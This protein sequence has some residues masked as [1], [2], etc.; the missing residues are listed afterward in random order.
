MENKPEYKDWIEAKILQKTVVVDDAGNYLILT[1]STEGFGSRKGKEDLCG[2]SMD[3]KDFEGGVQNAHE[4]AIAREVKEE[5]DLDAK[6]F[7]I[8]YVSS[9]TKM[10]Q[11]SGEIFVLALGYVCRVSGVKPEVKLNGKEHASFRWVSKEEALNADFGDDGGFHKAILQ[12]V[13]GN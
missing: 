8:I 9:G 5:T 12:E 6:N 4:I 10:T 7:K 3:K 1:R 11:S 13:R 2:G